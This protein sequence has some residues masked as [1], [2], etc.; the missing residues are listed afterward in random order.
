MHDFKLFVKRLARDR[1]FFRSL[2]SLSLPVA[3]QNLIISSLNMVDTIM[4]GRLG[5]K[6]IA[7]VAI[8]NQIYF[9]MIL[10]FFGIASGTAAFTAQYWGRGDTHRIH[11]ALGFCLLAVT[12]GATVF[13]L[14]V[15]LVPE[16][17][18]SFFTKDADVVRLGSRYLRIVAASYW[19]TAVSFAYANVLR[20]MG[21]VKMPLYSTAAALVLNTAGNY[22]LI[23]GSFG[24]PALGVAGAAAATVLSRAVETLILVVSV[25]RL[26]TPAASSPRELF[27]ISGSYVKRFFRTASP[28]ILNE[29]IWALGMTMYSFVYARMGTE[30]LASFTIADTLAKFAVVLFFGTS[31]ACAVMVG[32]RIGA[33]EFD[34]ARYYANAYALL[35]PVLGALMGILV[36]AALPLLPLVFNVSRA[37]LD[38]AKSVVI[39]F[40]LFLPAKIF[41]WH[42]VVGI[43]RSGG[44]TRYSLFLEGLGVWL[45]GVPLAVLAGLVLGLPVWCVY[46]ALSIEETVKAAVGFFR[47]RSGKWIHRLTHS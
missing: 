13:G 37:S 34:K 3:L 2:L 30:A 33:G 19:F 17:L 18:L 36:I 8:S 7:A 4:I 45:I 43:L 23:F 42:L 12:A 24:F 40:A 26:K 31:N 6:E 47:L 11:E 29:F 21:I 44:D 39:L 46:A 5:E 41:G 9:L 15:L 35:G 22:L 10:L 1:D 25:Y 14:T 27:S 16:L 28:V 38:D 32:N 20:S